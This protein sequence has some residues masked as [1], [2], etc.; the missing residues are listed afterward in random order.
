MSSR[1]PRPDRSASEVS[2]GEDDILKV[3]DLD[4]FDFKGID[5]VLS[6]PG[7]KVSAGIRAARR[8]GRLRSSSTTP[9]ASAWS[10]TCRWSCPK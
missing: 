7:A 6:S 2:F 5:I 4:N 10:R 9:R 1:S 3:Q 8:Q